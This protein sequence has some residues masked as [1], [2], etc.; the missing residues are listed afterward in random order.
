MNVLKRNQL[1]ITMAGAFFIIALL[2]TSDAFGAGRACR[3]RIAG[4]VTRSSDRGPIPQIRALVHLLRINQ[5]GGRLLFV[6]TDRDGNYAFENVCPGVYTVYPGPLLVE[7]TENSPIPSLYTPAFVRVRVP[8]RIND[9]INPAHIDFVR[10]E[11]PGR[12]PE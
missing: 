4:R 1:V 9:V 11:P 12:K 2:V 7:N 6:H 3:L 5:K 10:N 8:T